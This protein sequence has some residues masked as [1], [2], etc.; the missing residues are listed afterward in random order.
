MKCI[1][2]VNLSA[3]SFDTYSLSNTANGPAALAAPS[4]QAASIGLECVQGS[5]KCI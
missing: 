1:R 2:A 5:L 3:W 4:T